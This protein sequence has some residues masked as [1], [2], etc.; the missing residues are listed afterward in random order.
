MLVEQIETRVEQ[1]EKAGWYDTDKG[2]LFWYK[3]ENSWSCRDDR[4][5]EE[6]P[7][8][9]Y[10]P[11]VKKQTRKGRAPLVMGFVKKHDELFKEII[12]NQGSLKWDP[13]FWRTVINRARIE[14]GYSPKSAGMDIARFL[15][16][17]Y[18]KLQ[19]HSENEGK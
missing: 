10:R 7:T 19:K 6:Y 16:N 9:W 2:K 13:D 5:S 17:A 18:C 8:K 14:L 3:L 11:I 4:C 12:S 1:P 15:E